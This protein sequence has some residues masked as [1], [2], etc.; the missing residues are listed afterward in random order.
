MEQEKLYTQED[1]DKNYEIGK[2][3]GN[4]DN[5]N[6]YASKETL[7]KF[8]EVN[9][10]ID[11]IS[12]QTRDIHSAI[13]GVDNVGGLVKTV[14]RIEAQTMKTNGSVRGLQIWKSFIVGG[15]AVITM[16]VIPMITFIFFDKITQLNEKIETSQNSTVAAT[17]DKL[18]DLISKYNIGIK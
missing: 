1:M 14:E 5:H 4:G 6:L 7:E 12:C 16:I 13:F 3:I 2:R 15:M 10:K 17:V 9:T 8:C 18:S 11:V